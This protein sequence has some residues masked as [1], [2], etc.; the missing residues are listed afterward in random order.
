MIGIWCRFDCV[1]KGAEKG[2]NELMYLITVAY[3]V[4]SSQEN[5]YEG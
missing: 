2:V 4:L 1:E 5:R 3:E